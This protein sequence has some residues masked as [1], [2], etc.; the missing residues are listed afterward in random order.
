MKK[1]DRNKRIIKDKLYN[2][3]ARIKDN[4]KQRLIKA[5][6]LLMRIDS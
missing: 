4:K 1:L 2:S 6:L 3:N 5:S